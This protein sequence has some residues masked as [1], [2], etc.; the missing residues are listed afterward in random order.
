MISHV[1]EHFYGNNAVKCMKR[2]KV[3]HIGRDDGQIRQPQVCGTA[4]DELSLGCRI[5]DRQDPAAWKAF[6]H[7]QR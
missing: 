2:L 5:R 7:P 1:F 6:G 4:M 3:I